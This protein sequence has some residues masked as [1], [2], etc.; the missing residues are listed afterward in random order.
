MLGVVTSKKLQYEI[1]EF[2]IKLK[3]PSSIEF[4]GT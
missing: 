4:Y 3:G 2:C 1:L